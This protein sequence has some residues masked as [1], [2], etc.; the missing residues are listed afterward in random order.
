MQDF[1]RDH[2]TQLSDFENALEETIRCHT[3]VVGLVL[4][5]AASSQ[6]QLTVLVPVQ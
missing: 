4:L 3:T 2:A 5:W 1:V 6:L